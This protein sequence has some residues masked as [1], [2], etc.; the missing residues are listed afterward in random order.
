MITLVCRVHFT[1]F[2]ADLIRLRRRL[3]D[4]RPHRAAPSIDKKV[5]ANEAALATLQRTVAPQAAYLAIACGFF[6]L[7]ANELV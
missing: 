7:H 6:G 5:F 4:N 2:N 3:R 1:H